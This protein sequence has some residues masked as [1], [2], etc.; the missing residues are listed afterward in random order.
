MEN[1][2]YLING[3][4][5]EKDEILNNINL[6]NELEKQLKKE[7]HKNYCKMKRREY[8]ITHQPQIKEYILNNMDK[9]KGYQKIYQKKYRN[10]LKTEKPINETSINEGN[11]GKAGRPKKYK[12]DESLKLVSN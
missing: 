12:L 8:V 4:Y 11:A 9:I 1:T 3:Q 7:Y 2:K 6:K 5:Y 10:K